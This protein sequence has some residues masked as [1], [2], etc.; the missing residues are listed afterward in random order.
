MFNK[1]VE[2]RR[3][4]TLKHTSKLKT[5]NKNCNDDDGL[6]RMKNAAIKKYVMADFNVRV[7][8]ETVIYN[9]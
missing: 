4:L 6:K 7:L 5:R 8:E 3:N 1:C 9:I 2:K